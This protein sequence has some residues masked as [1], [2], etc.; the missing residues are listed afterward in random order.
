M[1][2]QLTRGCAGCRS[3]SLRLEGSGHSAPRIDVAD[4]GAAA[5]DRHQA[6]MAAKRTQRS[7]DHRLLRLVWDPGDTAI[8]TGVGV[9]RSTA[10]RSVFRPRPERGIAHD[11]E[12]SNKNAGMS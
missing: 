9:P 7:Y 6:G 10:D 3:L 5:N 8:A 4:G 1:A 12:Y 11:A 2:R